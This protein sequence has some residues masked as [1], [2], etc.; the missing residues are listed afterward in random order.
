DGS[1]WSLR[2]TISKTKATSA[3]LKNNGK[4]VEGPQ[5]SRVNETL[6]KL[7][8]VDY[9][10]FTRAIYSEQ[11]AIDMFLTIPKGSRMKK[12]D[13]LLAIDRFE[14]A[15]AT[16]TAVLNRVNVSVTD[17]QSLVS[18]LE[19]DSSVRNFQKLKTELQQAL[20]EK[21][22]GEQKLS[23]QVRYKNALERDLQEM[24]IKYERFVTI[25]QELAAKT[26]VVT[27]FDSDIDSLKREI[28]AD[29]ISYAEY[30]DAQ[31]REE[32]AKVESDENLFKA[33]AASENQRLIDLQGLIG[34]KQSKMESLDKEKIPFLEKQIKDRD[35]LEKQLKKKSPS[36]ILAVTGCV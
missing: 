5:P 7:L 15:R 36:K 18:T 17:K 8:K 9:D 19:N 28:T 21:Q 26:A 16:V 2:R 4:L 3:E 23:D 29:E 6:E 1:E 11:N 10:L 25:H 12:I 34:S 30:T 14:K 32:L 24:R 22:Q 31:I 27:Q 35:D 33:N 20:H 13:E